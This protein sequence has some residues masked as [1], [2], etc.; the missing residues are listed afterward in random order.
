MYVNAAVE[1]PTSVKL[2]PVSG[3]PVKRVN[4]PAINI[5][6]WTTTVAIFLA[7]AGLVATWVI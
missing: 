7:T 2:E 3:E 4:G 1:P 5:L 6:G